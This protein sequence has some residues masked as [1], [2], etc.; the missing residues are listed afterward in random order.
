MMLTVDSINGG[1][2][3]R[4][5]H[6]LF[7]S[8]RAHP[9]RHAAIRAQTP[10]GDQHERFRLP[11]LDVHLE[12]LCPTGCRRGKEATIGIRGEKRESACSLSLSVVR[13]FSGGAHWPD[14][15]S[16]LSGRGWLGR[17][18]DAPHLLR[19][20]NATSPRARSADQPSGQAAPLLH[21]SVY[22]V[23]RALSGA[24]TPHCRGYERG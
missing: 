2:R 6:R 11:Q 23:W 22:G 20:R 10:V 13:A 9:R 21:A 1:N 3:E 5:L 17:A 7:H 8:I 19:Q 24:S 4:D 15:T 14:Q 12:M 18:L 16:T